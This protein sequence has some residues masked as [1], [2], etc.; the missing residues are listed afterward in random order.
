M[1]RNG[2]PRIVTGSAVAQRHSPVW[3]AYL[4]RFSL[5]HDQDETKNRTATLDLAFRK[6]G[7]PH[8]H[9]EHQGDVLAC[10]K[11]NE[12]SILQMALDPALTAKQ[13]EN[14][15]LR[16]AAGEATRGRARNQGSRS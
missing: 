8:E 5:F 3:E 14:D 7:G 16:R 13:S 1:D 4:T 9:I 15:S 11:C 6:H 12:P 2:D 10:L